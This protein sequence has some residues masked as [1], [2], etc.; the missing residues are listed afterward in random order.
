MVTHDDLLI[1]RLVQCNWA[2]SQLLTSQGG[3]VRCQREFGGH[4]LKT[5]K[6]EVRRSESEVPPAG[7]QDRGASAIPP[8]PPSGKPAELPPWLASVRASRREPRKKAG[9][10]SNEESAPPAEALAVQS[11]EL[12]K[13][14]QHDKPAHPDPESAMA[15][16]R[17]AWEQASA[18]GEAAPQGGS[19]HSRLRKDLVN[20]NKAVVKWL[21]HEEIGVL[22]RAKLMERIRTSAA[23]RRLREAHGDGF[24]EEKFA[25]QALDRATE[26]RA[27]EGAPKS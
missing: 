8:A 20:L 15:Q 7:L 22:T 1:Y 16:V 5:L 14:V 11:L 18:E 2:E 21:A 23:A 27:R 19:T 24:Q 3:D 25:H 12:A 26:A 6:E 4:C 17:E 13:C 9:V 10:E